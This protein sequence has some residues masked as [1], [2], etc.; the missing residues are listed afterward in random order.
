[1]TFRT[2]AAA[3]SFVA[4]LTWAIAC[5][6]QSPTTASPT[7]A[8]QT[9]VDAT[10]ADGSTLKATAPGPISPINDQQLSDSPT[11]TVSTASLKFNQGTA[12]PLQYRFEVFNDAGNKVVDSGQVSGTSYKV[13]A[14][15]DFKKRHTWRARAEY[16]N[17]FGPW[18]AAA[19]FITPE[20]GYI[21][22]NEVFDPLTNGKTVGEAF[23]AT[24]FIPGKGIRL[25]DFSA[26]VRYQIP[27]TVTA[28]EFSME[29]EG[30]RANASGNKSKVFGAQQGTDDFITDPFR[31]DIQY[32]GATGSPANAITFRV[33]Y[34][35]ATKLSL[36]YE[37][38]TATRF[39]SVYNLDPGTTYY[40]KAVWG[41]GEF[42]VTVRQG[43]INGTPIYDV[44][45][46]TPNGAYNPQ[47]MMAFLGA[48]VGRSG[49][50]SASIAGAIYR[51]VWIA[52]RPRP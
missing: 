20:G 36:R 14:A 32:R 22:G 25:E 23:G 2:F 21:R 51:N 16:Q 37:P 10:G 4:L 35:S 5:N 34:G 44:G 11:L 3:A 13:T 45:V 6:R 40:W 49:A 33:L 26:F 48:P 7:S 39:A 9:S 43:G 38:D 42:R 52:A 8:A 41:S 19:S 31:M 30:L 15:L 1:M 24:T 12:P 27:V 28:G 29:V 18:S 46:P 47:P 17:A 50:E